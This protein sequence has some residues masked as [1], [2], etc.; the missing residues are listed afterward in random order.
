MKITISE[1]AA[2]A[3]VSTGTVS[4]V[5]NGH[6]TVAKE[7]RR[8]VLEVMEQLGYVPDPV[9]RELSMRSKHS[10]GMWVGE[11][12]NRLS[13]YFS[14]VWRALIKE[15]Q[16]RAIQFVEMPPDLSGWRRPLNAVLIFN[17]SNLEQRMSVLEERGLPSVLI[18]RGVGISCVAPDDIGGGRLAAQTL[19]DLG[20]RKLLHLGV[21]GDAQWHADRAEGFTE[22]VASASPGCTVVHMRGEQSVL[23]GYRV[24]RDA[25]LAGQRP[26][27]VFC[28]TDEMAVGAFGALTDLG[29]RIP[30]ATSILGFDGLAPEF[31][32][33]LA[34][35][36]QDIPQIAHEAVSLALEAIERRPPRQIVVPV[37]LL[38]GPSVGLAPN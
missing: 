17:S 27:G 30:E 26:S 10:I 29:V 32:P 21:L 20:H 5:L 15:M 23:G 24:M 12:E 35:I 28:A 18:G 33:G 8:K 13:P 1:I 7:T 11:G 4:R 37:H 16:D 3:G 6:S 34:T 2:H 9:A 31:H 14:R 38:A 25:W 19:L 22:L 36:A